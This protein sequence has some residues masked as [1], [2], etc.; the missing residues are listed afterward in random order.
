MFWDL[1]L[2]GKRIRFETLAY[3]KFDSYITKL[4]YIILEELYKL[5][6]THLH[7]R[8]RKSIR[9]LYFLKINLHPSINPEYPSLTKK[10][11]L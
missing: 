3:F 11:I 1:W 8:K 5:L 7:V 4:N 6:L 2:N 9:E 10:T